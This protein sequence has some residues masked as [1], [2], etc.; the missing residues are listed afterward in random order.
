MAKQYKTNNQ[1]AQTKKHP[2]FELIIFTFRNMRGP[3]TPSLTAKNY[4]FAVFFFKPLLT[5]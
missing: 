3:R 5:T 4:F 2:L 1:N